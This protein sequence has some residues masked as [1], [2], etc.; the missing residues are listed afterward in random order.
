MFIWVNEDWDEKVFL[1]GFGVRFFS[2]CRKGDR[3]F[4]E[5]S[6]RTSFPDYFCSKLLTRHFSGATA[7]QH[8]IS[9]F[10]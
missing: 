7:A 6:P 9:W 4:I 8:V 3:F 2:A 1:A 5:N 10:F